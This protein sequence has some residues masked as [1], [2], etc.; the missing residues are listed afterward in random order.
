M[1]VKFNLGRNH[2]LLLGFICGFLFSYYS[3][4]DYTESVTECP[5]VTEHT[6]KL[7]GLVDGHGAEFEPQ[8]NLEQKPMIAKKVVKNIVRPR[9]YYTE[10][11]IREKLFLGVLTTTENIDSLATAINRTAAHL[12]NKIKFFIHAESMKSNFQ[13]KNIVGFTD[14]RENLRPFHML[15]FLA[16]NYLDEYD[17][18]LLVTDTTYVNARML[19]NRLEHLSVTMDVYMG[20]PLADTAAE[21][22]G[23][24]VEGQGTDDESP[25]TGST[26]RYCDL[27]AGIIL[28]SG[29]IRKVRA[30]LDWCVRNA[31]GD[32]HSNNIGKCVRY[33]AKLNG[34]HD[35]WQGVP[36]SSYRLSSFKIYRDF[37][38]I[39]KEPS[40]NGASTVFPVTAAD[41]F[42]LLHAYFSRVHLETN[43]E[44]KRQVQEEALQIAGGAL[45][46]EVLE[47]R[48][49]LG[50]PRTS[51]PESRH[52]II[53][54]TALNLTHIFMRN[55]EENVRRLSVVDEEDIRNVLNKT[56][57]EAGRNQ[58]DDEY[59]G[60]HSAYKRFDAVRGMEYRL[61]LT[62]YDRRRK[63][64][65]TRSFEVI[66]PISLIEIV[67]S[68]YV[69]ESTR[70]A[71]LLPV[72]EQQV[73]ETEQFLESY[74]RTCMDSQDNTFLMLIFFYR[75]DTPSK[76]DEDV[77]LP[78]KNIALAVTEKH[79]QDGSRVAWVSIRLPP[80]L[81]APFD[82]NH[83][84][85]SS[86]YGAH[87]RLAF[88]AVDLAL[89]KIGLESLVLVCSNAAT[90]RPDFLNRVRMNTIQG[91][92]V[93][94]PIGFTMYPCEWTGLCKPCENCD[95]GQGIGYFDRHNYDVVSFY[96]NDYVA[97]RKELEGRLPIV[98]SDR[99]IVSLLGTNGTGQGDGGSL[100]NI[101]QLFLQAGTDLHVLRAIEPNLRLGSGIRNF[102][103]TDPQGDRFAK[104]NCP[105]P[106]GNRQRCIRIASK[107]QIG[108]LLVQYSK[109]RSD[110]QPTR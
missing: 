94:S 79:K 10:L 9:Y 4:Q 33:S 98:R 1:G 14:T 22:V 87:G 67:P 73:Q 47:V 106:H 83:R 107:K 110:S 11:G 109:Q 92:Q 65:R 95:V 54:W 45:S 49:P 41:D 57:T 84:Y 69:T 50:V 88:A 38:L 66:K 55:T 19:R 93:F 28:S 85:Y 8:L 2:C 32:D 30:N 12:V 5:E 89:R 34:C 90:F 16:D 42:Y 48:W 78:L 56:I 102:L 68:P 40:F 75:L 37:H 44:R 86:L 18:F 51:P 104:L 20:R 77:F 71:I 103:A 81:S 26:G 17:Y 13:L 23:G 74:E 27:N 80:E 63:R 36:V 64:M 53:K 99:D 91:F 61:L 105:E 7:N 101:V 70:V 82:D 39:A 31:L 97:V 21:G 6:N 29:V 59:R 100:T 25:G 35:R 52:D 60:L 46:N 72:L 3:P 96:S 108:D 15:K 62:F 58:P 43:N 76:G 24:P